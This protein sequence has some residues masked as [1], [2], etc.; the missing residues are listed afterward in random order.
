MKNT[1]TKLCLMLF[2]LSFVQVLF[3]QSPNTSTSVDRSPAITNPSVSQSLQNQSARNGNPKN[4]TQAIFDIQFNYLL[5]TTLG[6]SCVYTGTEF[7]VGCYGTDSI[8]TFDASGNLTSGFT[9]AGVGNASSG[10]R[11]LTYDGTYIYATCNTA[12][13]FQIDPVTKTLI[14]TI[15]IPSASR[16]I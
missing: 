13:I 2:V 6:A 10:V 12:E 3:A 14:G 1:S 9:V 16:G 8:Y 7:W 15:T 4:E 11:G 5:P